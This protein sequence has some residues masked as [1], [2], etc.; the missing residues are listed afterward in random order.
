MRPVTVQR[1]V[2]PKDPDDQQSTILEEAR[3]AE[4]HQTTT[5]DPPELGLVATFRRLLRL[6]WGERRLGCSGSRSRSSTRCM[7]VAIPLLQQR[8]RSTTRSCPPRTHHRQSLWPYLV[9]IV[10]LGAMR[11]AINFLRRYATARI[12]IRI[13]ARMRELLY[14]AY[15]RYPRAFYDRHATGQVLS[16]ATNDLYPIRYFIGWGLVQGVQSVMMIVGGRH[17]ARYRQRAARALHRGRD[18]ADHGCSSCASP[19]ASRRSRAEVQA[20]QGR[21]HRGGRRGGRRDRDGAGV[22]PRGRRARPLRRARPRRCATPCCARRASRHA[23]LP[24]LYYLPALSIAAVVFFGGQAGDRRASSRSASS[25]SSR[26]CSCSSCG[27]SRRS[28][29]S[30]TSRSARSPR[31][32]AAS[33]GSRGSSR[34]RSRRRRGRCPPGRCAVRFEAVHFAYGG[35]HDVLHDLDLAIE[36]RRDRRRLRLDGLGQDVAAQPAAALLRPDR[37]PRAGRRSRHARRADRGAAPRGRARDAAPGALLGTAAR[38]PHRRTRATRDWDDVLAACDAA[39]VDAFADELPDGYD[40]LIGE[41]GVNLS[42]GQRQRVALARALVTDARVIVLDDPLS[43]VDTLTERRLVRRLRP[44]L[45]GRTVLHRDAAAV[46]GRARRPR[47]R[48]ARR[49]A[50]SSRAAIG[51]AAARRRR[52]HR[53]LRRRGGGMRRLSRYL[54]GRRAA[55]GA[56]G[57]RRHRQ[58]RLP[59]GRLAARAE[60]DRQ[61]HR[62]ATTAHQ[63][64]ASSPSTSASPRAG[65]VLQAW[66]IRGL[67]GIGQRIMLGLRRDLFDHLT[68][69]SLRYFSQQKAGWIIAR[70]TSDVDAVSDVLSQGMPTLVSNAVLLPVAVDRAAHRRLAARPRRVRGRAARRSSCTRWFQ[71]RR[72]SR[73]SRRATGSPR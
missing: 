14:Q 17:R 38:E 61:G 11:F 15:L 10:V 47:G 24:G 73:S 25:S 32:A 18:A 60:R 69:L 33:P 3:G 27:R 66:L 43:A 9:A 53:A 68:G 65:W 6:W 36:R 44:A 41:R 28:A 34:C 52:L 58:R 8:R 59:D 5:V 54:E 45:A 19:G 30:R 1:G 50:S 23:H 12:G 42:G 16:R 20:A 2:A 29:G 57:A 4:G 13:E 70:L 22:R 49:G 40:T 21:R 37:R 67:A 35:G 46:D 71:R 51:R 55:R 56:A 62:G 26:R 31:P 7:S 72:T 63:L 39:G 64:T 48:A